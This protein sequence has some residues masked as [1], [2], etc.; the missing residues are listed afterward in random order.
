MAGLLV[1][2]EEEQGA[3]AAV[4]SITLHCAWKR[5]EEDN[6]GLV[7]FSSLHYLLHRLWLCSTPIARKKRQ[8]YNAS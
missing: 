4:N 6:E 5:K 3:F 2:E 1:D 7:S 8:R